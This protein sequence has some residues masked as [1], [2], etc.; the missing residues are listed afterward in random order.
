MA[1]KYYEF[2]KVSNKKG[3][4]EL[5]ELRYE[6]MMESRLNALLKGLECSIELDVYD[7]RAEHYGLFEIE[8]L[9]CRAVGYMRVIQSTLSDVSDLILEIAKDNSEALYRKLKQSANHQLPILEYF[10]AS[11]SLIKQAMEKLPGDTWCEA[12]RFILKKEVRSIGLAQFFIECGFACYP[13][14]HCLISC[15]AGH[16]RIYRAYEAKTLAQNQ[17]SDKIPYTTTLMR[18][19]PR[20]CSL[21]LKAK[22]ERMERTFLLTGK[23]CFN[24]SEPNNFLSPEIQTILPHA[25]IKVA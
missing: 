21:A 2:K 7:T 25:K 12:S 18:I 23:V 8:G 6:T 11:S 3:L 15:S 24:K 17:Y 1:T 19:T 4:T 13:F 16:S 10:K 14:D 9:K 5:F 22:F 20:E